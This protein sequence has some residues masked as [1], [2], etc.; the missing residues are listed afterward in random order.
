M[1]LWK[2]TTFSEKDWSVSSAL[3]GL[4]L[5]KQIKGIFVPAYRYSC[6]HQ[7]LK[8]NKK[9]TLPCSWLVQSEQ[10]L[11]EAS[12]GGCHWPEPIQSQ[13]PCARAGEGCNASRRSHPRT[14]PTRNSLRHHKPN[15]HTRSLSVTAQPQHNCQV[16]AENPKWPENS[17]NP[18]FSNLSEVDFYLFCSVE[19][20]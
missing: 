16:T 3:Q 10:R 8:E 15:T 5:L 20:W 4:V 7:A 2:A 6:H 9:S 14:L 12:R 17:L 1:S 18:W 11:R 13:T 19:P